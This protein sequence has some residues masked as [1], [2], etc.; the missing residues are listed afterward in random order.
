MISTAT[1]SEVQD[2]FQAYLNEIGKTNL[3]TRKEEVE[4]AKRIK[5]GD[6][7]ARERMIRANLR[8]VVKLAQDYKNYGLPILDLISEGNL[9]LIKAVEKFDPKKGAKFSTYASWWIKQSIRRALANQSKT[10]RLPVY[11]TDKV[12]RMRRI[13]H[14]LSDELGRMPTDDELAMEMETSPAQIALLRRVSMETLSLD[15]SGQDDIDDFTLADR[16]GDE[17][18]ADP[19]KHLS[20]QNLQDTA[21][22]ALKDLD[23]RELKILSLRFGLGGQEIQTL[24]EIG[25]QFNVTRERIRQLQNSALKKIKKAIQKLDS[26][27]TRTIKRAKCTVSKLKEQMAAE[28]KPVRVRRGRRAR[29]RQ[30]EESSLLA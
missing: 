5:K 13:Q 23:E 14:Q 20:R 8:L 4:L 16:I 30:T 24:S 2:A 18:S 22:E 3:L 12:Q 21:M 6:E 1:E 15:A 11:L 17:K 10:I 28:E 19:S 27:S 9:G 7:S 25:R 26:E 29:V